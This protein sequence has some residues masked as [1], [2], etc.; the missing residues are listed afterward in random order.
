MFSA[1]TAIMTSP[2]NDRIVRRARMA[3]AMDEQQARSIV[4]D[5]CVGGSPAIKAAWRAH[6]TISLITQAPSSMLG[7]SFRGPP[8]GLKGVLTASTIRTSLG[9]L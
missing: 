7:I 8:K 9:I 5:T 3:L 6:L 1:P 2:S 4:K